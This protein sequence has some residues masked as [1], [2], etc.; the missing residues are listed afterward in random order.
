MP[1]DTR[2]NI[3]V[4]EEDLTAGLMLRATVS[5][6][7]DVQKS[8]E[9]FVEFGKAY[10]Q[11]WTDMN[12]RV[13]QGAASRVKI[14]NE[15]ETLE[16]Q[17]HLIGKHAV[18]GMVQMVEEYACFSH[19]CAVLWAS[20]VTAIRKPWDAGWASGGAEE[21]TQDGARQGAKESAAMAAMFEQIAALQQRHG[22]Q[23]PKEQHDE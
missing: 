10:L 13:M 21:G 3:E 15:S 2:V 9:V 23:P 20:C 6:A 8:F 12:N 19:R 7:P 14:A 4:S 1:E 18:D 16:E 17:E 22:P 11:A 5:T